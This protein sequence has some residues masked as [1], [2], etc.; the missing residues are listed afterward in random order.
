MA[1]HFACAFGDMNMVK[2][3]IGLGANVNG[4]DNYGCSPL[5][6]ACSRHTT[7]I[8]GMILT[9]GA[10]ITQT[11]SNGWSPI[12]HAFAAKNLEVVGLLIQNGQNFEND[13]IC[14]IKDGVFSLAQLLT[15]NGTQVGKAL[16]IE[17][18]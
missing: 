3:A 5:M 4:P 12:R 15:E 10:N 14:A 11:D 18:I 8:V 1:L 7:E 13:L 6:I 16:A 2:D 17:K 9:Y